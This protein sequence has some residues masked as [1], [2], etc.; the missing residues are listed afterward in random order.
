MDYAG[1]QVDVRCPL[2]FFLSTLPVRR[3]DLRSLALRAA[4]R[5][6]V[7]LRFMR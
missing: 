1:I 4:L 5:L 6:A 7:L 2:V 3:R